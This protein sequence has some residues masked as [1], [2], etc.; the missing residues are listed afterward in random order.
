MERIMK[1]MGISAIKVMIII[2]TLK[3]GINIKSQLA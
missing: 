1:L 2:T 3:I